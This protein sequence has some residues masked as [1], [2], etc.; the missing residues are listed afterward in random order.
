MY[1]FRGWVASRGLLRD[2]H[3]SLSAACNGISWSFQLGDALGQSG[4]DMVFSAEFF[5]A[6]DEFGPQKRYLLFEGSDQ[7]HVV[8]T[9]I[10]LIARPITVGS[11]LFGV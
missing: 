7:A 3:G 9:N 4:D 8:G 10:R 2:L 11:R 1:R 5:V 6:G